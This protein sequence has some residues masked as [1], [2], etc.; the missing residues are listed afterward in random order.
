MVHFVALPKLPSA[1]VTA[2]LL[3]KHVVRLHGI[4]QNIVS[5]RGPQFT[6][7]VWRAFCQGIGATVSLSSGYHPQTNGQAERANQALEATLHCVPT[8]NPASWSLHLPWV[9]YSLNTMVN[10]ATGLSLFLCSIGYQPQE[11]EAAVPSVRAHLRRCRRIWK[12]ARDAMITNWDRVERSANRRRV[13]APAYH[14][15]QRVWLLARDLPLPTVSHKLAPRYIGPYP[16]A[17]VIN[18]SAL[19]LTLPPPS[20]KV[21]P[22]FH[23]SQVK[24]VATSGLSPPAPTPPPPRT[25][26]GGD[27]VWDVNRILVVRRRPRR[28]PR[29]A[30]VTAANPNPNPNPIHY[31]VDWVGYGPEDWTWVPRSYLADPALLEEFYR[32]NPSAIGRSPGVSRRE[33][34]PVAGAAAG[35]VATPLPLPARSSERADE[36]HC[37]SEL[38]NNTCKQSPAAYKNQPDPALLAE[39][40]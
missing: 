31:L 34:G 38:N 33:G 35:A 9:E 24:P 14:P 7:G 30:T 18:P 39:T 22:I 20:L 6:S 15:Y 1:A 32:A 28:R 5:D 16:V 10:A 37:S 3:V 25:L 13:P 8:S 29:S 2:D 4:L 36:L 40:F 23:V 21:H 11:M 19:R 27:L 12:T 26:E 17:Q